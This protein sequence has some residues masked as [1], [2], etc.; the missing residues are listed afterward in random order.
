MNANEL[1]NNKL[2]IVISFYVPAGLQFKCELALFIAAV[3]FNLLSKRTMRYNPSF[4]LLRLF[5][6]RS[7]SFYRISNLSSISSFSVLSWWSLSS[8]CRKHALYCVFILFF[9]TWGSSRR[10]CLFYESLNGCHSCRSPFYILS[11]V[12]R[13]VLHQPLYLA[14]CFTLFLPIFPSLSFFSSFSFRP[15]NRFPLLHCAKL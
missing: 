14:A 11:I 4:S 6:F 5:V 1:N 15:T 3:L 8:K 10:E 7:F 9:L 2:L 13:S 12:R